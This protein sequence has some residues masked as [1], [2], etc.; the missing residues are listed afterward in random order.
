ME[1]ALRPG[2][3][4]TLEL[5]QERRL[6]RLEKGPLGQRRQETLAGRVALPG[7][8]RA[9]TGTYWGYGVRI[10]TGLSEALAGC[11]YEVRQVAQQ[12]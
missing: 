11:P 8:P 3:R 10:A 7:E 4:V 5:G 9:K 6:I 12:S 2:V 1:Q